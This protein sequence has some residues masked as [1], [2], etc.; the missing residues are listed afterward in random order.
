M[1]SPQDISRLRTQRDAALAA[2]VAAEER[3]RALDLAIARAQRSERVAELTRLQAER[4]AQGRAGERARADYSRLHDAAL[5]ELVA[6]LDQTPEQ[7]VGACSDSFPFVLLPVRLETK[8]ARVGAATE[9]R[10]RFFPDEIG[11]APPIAASSENERTLGMSYWRARTRS[12]QANG[13]VALE[14]AYRASWTALVAVAGP[15]RA[16]Y[17]VAATQPSNPGSPA[18]ELVFPENVTTSFAPIV[19]AD[20][21]PDR[22]VVLMYHRDPTSRALNQVGRAIGAPIADN[23]VLAPADE[24][25]ESWLTRNSATGQL[26][27]PDALRWLVDFDRAV[28]MGMA[29]RIPVAPPFDQMGFDRVVAVGVRSATPPDQA[30]AAVE[31]LLAAHRYSHGCSIVSSGT[32]TN[33][34]DTVHSGWPAPFDDPDVLF[35]I[36]DAPPVIEASGVHA[37]RSDGSRLAQL[38]GLGTEL[39]RRLPNAGR[40]DIAE[41]LAMNRA[42]AAGTL[43]DFV[44]RIPEGCGGSTNGRESASLLRRVGKWTRPLSRLAGRPPALRH[45]R[46]ERMGPVVAGGPHTDR[47]RGRAGQ[48]LQLDRYP[49]FSLAA[50]FRTCATRE[51]A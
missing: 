43:D 2:A 22:F 48:C 42:L 40:T 24:Q 3:I 28:S 41:A 38:F 20:S 6:M 36:E 16:S 12:G 23:L 32:P 49:S 13:D 17:V 19:R 46:F 9:L 35:A 45:R 37:E 1:P 7:I 33:N 51:P 44:G 21:L 8:F 4:A 18:D 26:D 30:P 34:T 25:P 5:G 11:I 29:L 27:V 47:R 14:M 39:V 50:S 31:S 15:Y 10:V